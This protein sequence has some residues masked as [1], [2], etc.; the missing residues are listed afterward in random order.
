MCA[1]PYLDGKSAAD[2]ESKIAA[3]WV[4]TVQQDGVKVTHTHTHTHTM[5]ATNLLFIYM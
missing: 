2:L 3:F 1:G 5:M 4:L